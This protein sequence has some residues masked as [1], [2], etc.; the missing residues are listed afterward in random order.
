MLLLLS[1]GLQHARGLQHALWTD[2]PTLIIIAAIQSATSPPDSQIQ[3]NTAQLRATTRH[4]HSA[5]GDPC[6]TGK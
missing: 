4:T 3:Q 1:M 6:A 2:A 5:R